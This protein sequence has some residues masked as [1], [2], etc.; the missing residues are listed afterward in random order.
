MTPPDPTPEQVIAERFAA[1]VN[2]HP[3]NAAGFAARCVEAIRAE[4]GPVGWEDVRER[5]TADGPVNA[6]SVARGDECECDIGGMGGCGG[7]H[8][9]CY[10]RSILSVAISRAE[11]AR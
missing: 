5:L 9:D 4:C 8:T 1:V 11:E 7:T 2:V 10:Y 3:E 6:A